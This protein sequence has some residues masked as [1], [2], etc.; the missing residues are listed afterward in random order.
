MNGFVVINQ[1]V[2]HGH[3]QKTLGKIDGGFSANHSAAYGDGVSSHMGNPDKCTANKFPA[4]SVYHQC[5]RNLPSPDW[6][7]LF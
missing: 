6:I 5:Y 3:Q 1:G 2:R 4:I 7:L